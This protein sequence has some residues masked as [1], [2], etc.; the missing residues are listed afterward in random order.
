MITF[1]ILQQRDSVAGFRVKGHAG[2]SDSGS[3]IVCAAVSVLV[4]NAIN[5]CERF[6]GVALNVVDQG[7]T[8]TCRLP[9]QPNESVRLLINSLFYG[10][11]QVAEQYPE[12]VRITTT[13][14]AKL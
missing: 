11:E 14:I 9:L 13:N 2:Y 12:F 8:L 1:E 5:S 4:Y 7:E 3:D 10:V 6:A